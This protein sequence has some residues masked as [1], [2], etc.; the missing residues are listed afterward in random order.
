MIDGTGMCGGCR[1][2]VG[3]EAKF[4]CVDGPEFDAHQVDFDNLA[5]RLTM[6]RE[7]EAAAGWG[8]SRKRSEPFH[9][10]A[11]R[12]QRKREFAR[13]FLCVLCVLSEPAS[14]R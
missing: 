10:K 12:S 8:W 11:Q 6:Y 5:D 7:H 1:V 13:T 3:G 4:A 2:V 14:G 9:R